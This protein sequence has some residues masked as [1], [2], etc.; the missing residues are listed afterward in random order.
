MDRPLPE[1]SSNHLPSNHQAQAPSLHDYPPQPPSC[2]SCALVGCLL[3]AIAILGVSLFILIIIK[4]PCK[5]L[6]DP[7]KGVLCRE[8]KVTV[9]PPNVDEIRALGRLDTVEL[10]LS[11]VVTVK[12]RRGWP[13]KF[14]EIL[15]YGVCGRVI[16]GVNLTKLKDQDVIT[17]GTI[18]TIS[19][20][21]A[22]VFSVDPTLALNVTETDEHPT[23]DSDKTVQVLP[24]CNY[25]YSWTAPI[26]R[27]PELIR[28]A[29]EQAMIQFRAIAEE[30]YILGKAQHNA[31]KEM[32]RF[33]MF[34]GYD[35]VRFVENPEEPV[36]PSGWLE[37]MM[38][39][40]EK[41]QVTEE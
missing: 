2:T 27:T 9:S 18:I 22:E 24:A 8:R 39:Q 16:A 6:P 20:P 12:N 26:G 40:L 7:I 34:T 30:G 37:E 11:T 23:G 1:K 4:N 41:W 17:S 15:V 28:V 21:R 36:E 13:I 35:E 19:L 38:Q 14:D 10:N 29:Q 5:V 33:L 25:A 32:A 3:S 31:E